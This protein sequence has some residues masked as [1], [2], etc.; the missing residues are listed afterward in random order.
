MAC[1]LLL[2][3]SEGIS[4]RV[5]GSILAVEGEVVYSSQPGRAS[6]RAEVGST[7]SLGAVIRTAASGAT[8]IEIVPGVRVQLG[9]NSELRVD[10]LKLMKD[11]NETQGGMIG[12]IARATLNRGKAT[13]SFDETDE[14]IGQFAIATAHTTVNAA[15][16]SVFV[17]ESSDASTR[18]TCVRG[19]LFVAAPGRPTETIA[20]GYFCEATASALRKAPAAEDLAAQSAVTEALR[21][22]EQLADLP[23]PSLVPV[24]Q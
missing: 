24:R 12:R 3:C 18:V 16:G 19:S 7:F 23:P 4:R 9:K 20:G 11:G 22:A 15:R 14:P 13:A 21:I 2:S 1:S 10:E 17:V 6:Q 8:A 5:L